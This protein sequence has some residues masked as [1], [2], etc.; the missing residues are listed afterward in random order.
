MRTAQYQT[1]TRLMLAA[2]IVGPIIFVLTFTIESATRPGYSPYNNFVS[3]LA[4]G[5]TG[6]VQTVNF[7]LYGLLMLVFA[8]GMYRVLTP[9]RGKRAVVV[10]L[11]VY[12]VG[13]LVAGSF[14]TDPALSYPPGT[15]P[16]PPQHLTTRGII[17]GLVGGMM[18]FLS[19]PILCFV[20]TW[21]LWAQRAWALYSLL[22]GLV[23]LV[24]SQ[25][26]TVADILG[27][28]TGVLQRIAIVVGW[29]WI[30]LLA[31]SELRTLGR[32]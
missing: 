18:S 17:H 29:A 20:M 9:G 11:M 28:P 23:M 12:A 15:P 19:V 27:W 14:T 26:S 31:T 24:V 16:G 13:L 3:Q 6:W 30:V 10:L 32:E 21:R 22:T 4:T 25:T 2:G 7:L 1:V 5:E 8:A